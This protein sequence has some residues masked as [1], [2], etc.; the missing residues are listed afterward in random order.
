MGGYQ[1]GSD[2]ELDQ[3]VI[4]IPRIYAALRQDPGKP[5]SVD[6][7]SELAAALRE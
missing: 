2:P 3:A 5:A 7:F 4:V 6:A 1:A